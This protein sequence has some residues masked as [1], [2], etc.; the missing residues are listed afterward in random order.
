MKHKRQQS[1]LRAFI[2]NLMKGK[3]ED[4]INDAQHSFRA[5]IQLARDIQKRKQSEKS[6]PID[7]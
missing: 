6:K 3:S 1:H 2:S 7:E 4:E 5:Y